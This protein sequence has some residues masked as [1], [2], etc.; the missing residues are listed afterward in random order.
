[1]RT[2][3]TRTLCI[4]RA[5]RKKTS[6]PDTLNIMGMPVPI[7]EVAQAADLP[8]EAMPVT[9]N[10]LMSDTLH[11][12]IADADDEAEE[13]AK[14][15]IIA[16]LGAQFGTWQYPFTGS[17]SSIAVMKDSIEIEV[18]TQLDDAIKVLKGTDACE[19]ESG[20]AFGR[21]ELHQGE[22]DPIVFEGPYDV[23]GCRILDIDYRRAMCSLLLQLLRVNP[24]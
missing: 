15:Y 13:L 16:I 5:M 8:Q 9:D 20:V 22:D 6:E 1:M 19:D 12:R 18:R 11:G 17:L 2:F 10:V 3:S 21:I 23:G 24:T 4:I 14:K 7:A